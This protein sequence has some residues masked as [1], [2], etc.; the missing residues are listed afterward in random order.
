MLQEKR[1]S[2]WFGHSW[3]PWMYEQPG[4]WMTRQCWKCYA[5]EFK[6]DTEIP[7]KEGGKRNG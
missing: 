2:C 5:T 6:K 4:E 3:Y 1:M 7:I